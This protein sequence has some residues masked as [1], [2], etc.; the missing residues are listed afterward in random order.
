MHANAFVYFC[1]FSISTKDTQ[2]II[3]FL[4]YLRCMT[5]PVSHL[6]SMY[7]FLSFIQ[8]SYIYNKKQKSYPSGQIFNSGLMACL[9]SVWIYYYVILALHK[10]GSLWSR[11]TSLVFLC[12]SNLN[13]KVTFTEHGKRPQKKR[14]LIV[15]LTLPSQN[16]LFRI[17]YLESLWRFI[18]QVKLEVTG[19][20]FDC[21]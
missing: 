9:A 18:T 8:L 17:N 10:K 5:W 1:L 19:D 12:F 3:G 6:R 15:R 13:K 4:F 20:H 14:P 2:T 7:F 16:G 21:S 11:K